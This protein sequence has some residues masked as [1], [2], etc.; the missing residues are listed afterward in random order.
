MLDSAR[1]GRLV[2][3]DER[4]QNSIKVVRILRGAIELA[5]VL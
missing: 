3:V 2:K 1:R 5:Q 4:P